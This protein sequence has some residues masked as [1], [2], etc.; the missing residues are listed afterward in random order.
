MNNR[1]SCENLSWQNVE[2]EVIMS[3]EQLQTD[4]VSG[5]YDLA[6]KS[7]VDD[8]IEL[9]IEFKSNQRQRNIELK[10]A[11]EQ[12][13]HRALIDRHPE[14]CAMKNLFL[15][16]N[17]RAVATECFGS[18]LVICGSVFQLKYRGVGENKWHHDRAFEDG[19]RPVDLHDN[20][21]HFTVLFALTD[22][23]M[24][25]GRIEY[26]QGSHLPIDGFDRSQRFMMELPAE[27][28]DR[29][30]PLT[31]KKGQFAVFYSSLMHRSLAFAHDEKTWSPN[32]FGKPSTSNSEGIDYSDNSDNGGR[33]SLA[34]RLM[35]NGTVIPDSYT[36][37]ENSIFAFN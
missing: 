31:M 25:Q 20:G 26:V 16:E 7:L 36:H 15:D 23:G 22:F 2:L 1:R 11:G 18:D 32:Y 27:V 9:A 29:V 19:D 13:Y 33:I 12:L 8:V 37:P 28:H 4:G 21:N 34:M 30:Q 10:A 24:N 35:R 6:D 5:P 17:V 14:F 3:M